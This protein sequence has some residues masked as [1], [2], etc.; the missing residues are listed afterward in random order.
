MLRNLKLY[1]YLSRKISRKISRK[2]S[3]SLSIKKC[4]NIPILVS[5]LNTNV[6]KP[7]GV[8]TISNMNR[9]ETVQYSN[10][11]QQ[12]RI[13][14]DEAV[15][16]KHGVDSHIIDLFPYT[17]TLFFHNCEKNFVFYNLNSKK[18]PNLEKLY[19][20]AHPCDFAV[21]HRFANKPEYTGYLTT[22]FYRRYLNRWWYPTTRHVKELTDENYKDILESFVEVNPSFE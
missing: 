18:F 12:S 15:I 5:S 6:K 3:L 1:F 14:T 20:L 22:P 9:L 10:N 13:C 7:L 19:C 4:M 8:F 17:K 21:M 11:K 2:M 16:F